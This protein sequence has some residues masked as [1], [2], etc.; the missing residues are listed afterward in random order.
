M[1]E[2]NRVLKPG[3]YV[4]MRDCDPI[5]KNTGP[6]GTNLYKNRKYLLCIIYSFVLKLKC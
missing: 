6:I 5:M 1:S 3:G 4:E 2:V